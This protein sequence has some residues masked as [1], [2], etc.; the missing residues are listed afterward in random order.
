[1]A[2]SSLLTNK[3]VLPTIVLSLACI[4]FSSSFKTNSELKAHSLSVTDAVMKKVKEHYVDQQS[5]EPKKMLISGLSRMEQVVDRVLVDF[6]KG[7]DSSKF[8]VQIADEKLSFDMNRIESLSDVLKVLQKSF[9]SVAP[10]LSTDDPKIIDVEYEVLNRMLKTLDDHSGIITPRVYKEFVIETEGSFGGLG[11]VIAIRDGE[12]TVISPIEGTPADLAG[13]KPNDKIVQIENESTVNMPFL[14][15]VSKLRGSKGTPVTISVNRKGFSKPKEFKIVRD[16]IR[17]EGVEVF[18]LD[19]GIHYVRIRDFQKNTLKTV[20]ENLNDDSRASKGMILDL[21]GNPGGLLNQAEKVSDFF[22]SSGLIVTTKSGDSSTD[23]KAKNKNPEYKGSVVV[24]VDSGSASASEIVAGALKNNER[25]IIVGERTFGKGSVQQ[26]FHLDDGSAL[27][28][29]V[30]QYLTPGDG[31]IQDVGVTPDVVLNPSI[32]SEELIL[33]NSSSGDYF[34]EQKDKAGEGRPETEKPAY[35]IRYLEEEKTD[36]EKES[37]PEEALSREKKKGGLETDFYVLLAKRILLSS[38]GTSRKDALGQIQSEISKVSKDE[39]R[40]A[41]DKWRDLGVDWSLEQTSTKIPPLS[42]K[43][44]PKAPEGTAGEVIELKVEVENSGSEPIYRLLATTSSENAIFTGKELVFG[45][46]DPGQKRSWNVKFDIPKW[47]LTRR[48][49]ITLEFQDGNDSKI[50]DF[51]F[52]AQILSLPRPLYA[53]NYEIVDDGRHGSIGNGNGV[54]DPDETIVLL[55]KVK[56]IGEGA[57][58]KATLTLKNDSGDAIF[59]EKGRDEVESLNSQ[60]IREAQL[61]FKVRKSA[62]SIDMKLQITDEALREG[63][64]GKLRIPSNKIN[65]GYEKED[66]Y[67][68]VASDNASIKGGGYAEAPLVGIAKKGSVF[69]TLGRSENWV[70]VRI[71]ENSAGWIEER[72]TINSEL[73]GGTPLYKE[74]FEAPPVISIQNLPTST[75][76]PTLQLNGVVRD[77]DGVELIWVFVGDDK[78]AMLPT[79]DMEVPLSVELELED[80][81]NL[82]TVLAKDSKSLRSRRSFIVRKEG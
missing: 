63:I 31:S 36:D 62:T 38:S 30:A 70:K 37:V 33:F 25:A 78:V 45:K 4:L 48:D 69:N 44:I 51:Q 82:I 34:Y 81:V 47:V 26:I 68:A 66:S 67:V 49:E 55:V 72:K 43:V 28:L 64:V 59:L 11:I 74:Q 77:T 14:E 18:K 1:M 54:A 35:S 60:A 52:N 22:L 13:I 32:I 3:L 58:E 19:N 56:N 7:E 80:R 53:F 79:S 24:L 71:G 29:T 46:L 16:T 40:K 8:Y 2:R 9:N 5:I 17:I 23:Y 6:P 21:R 15:A 12:L 42:V 75:Q 39:E 76:S 61:A 65:P 20:I 50:K 57:S 27:K 73:V 41:I 10:H